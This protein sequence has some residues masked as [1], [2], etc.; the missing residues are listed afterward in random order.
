TVTVAQYLA[1]IASAPYGS[2]VVLSDTGANIAAL[3]SS[4]FAALAGNN[5]ASIVTTNHAL[6]LT[7]AQYQALGAVALSGADY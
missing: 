3:T 1:Q 6:S 4:Q 2:T 5:V 7:V